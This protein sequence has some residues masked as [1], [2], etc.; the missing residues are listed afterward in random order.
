MHPKS[1]ERLERLNRYR[2]ERINHSFRVSAGLELQPNVDLLRRM[3]LHGLKRGLQLD[4]PS[5][6]YCRMLPRCLY[7]LCYLYYLCS[8]LNEMAR[9]SVVPVYEEL[10]YNW[11]VELLTTTSTLN[12]WPVLA[13]QRRLLQCLYCKSHSIV[14]YVWAPRAGM[15]FLDAS[16]HQFS[17]HCGY[18]TFHLD[19]DGFSSVV[20]QFTRSKNRRARGLSLSVKLR[21]RAENVEVLID[22]ESEHAYHLHAKLPLLEGFHGDL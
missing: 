14:L 11:I 17:H 9:A 19:E 18:P 21:A 8:N 16:S 5:S 15:R 13:R 6:N 7:Y 1:V 20:Q 10:A 22:K 4:G 2:Y 3:H 12:G